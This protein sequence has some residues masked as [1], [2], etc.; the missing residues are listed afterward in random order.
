M[1]KPLEIGAFEYSSNVFRSTARKEGD[2]RVATARLAVTV[3]QDVRGDRLRARGSCTGHS[4]SCAR[5]VALSRVQGRSRYRHTAT[6]PCRRCE[7]L[8]GAECF[9]MDSY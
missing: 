9:L 4:R 1:R 6:L 2:A 3:P 5:A 8:P 7:C